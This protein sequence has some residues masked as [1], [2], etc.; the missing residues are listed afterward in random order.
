MSVLVALN[1]LNQY[2]FDFGSDV[3]SL[4]SRVAWLFRGCGFNNCC[5]RFLDTGLANLVLSTGIRKQPSI[6]HLLSLKLFSMVTNSISLSISSRVKEFS[7]KR[8][9]AIINLIFAKHLKWNSLRHLLFLLSHGKSLSRK[10]L[11]YIWT[12]MLW[13]TKWLWV[14]F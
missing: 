8:G 6:K 4:V 10:V 5:Y 7:I 1:R 3:G 13:P 9:V 14:F 12:L 2:Y 11:T